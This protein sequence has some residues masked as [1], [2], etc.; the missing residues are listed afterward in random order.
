MKIDINADHA[1]ANLATLAD[2]GDADANRLGLIHRLVLL[3]VELADIERQITG[4]VIKGK[5]TDDGEQ[6][7][8]WQRLNIVRN[9]A[10]R[11]SKKLGAFWGIEVNHGVAVVVP[12]EA[13]RARSLEAT[14]VQAKRIAD[15]NP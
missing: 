1:V 2:E 7:G 15:A 9:H 12:A 13:R 11:M 6:L 4:R 3:Q 5:L 10:A 14:K 8:V